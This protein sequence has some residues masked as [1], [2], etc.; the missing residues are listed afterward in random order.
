MSLS[1]SDDGEFR[2]GE[3]LVPAADI[4][5][6]GTSVLD[7]DGLLENPIQLHE[8]LKE[9]CGGQLWPAGVALVKYLLHEQRRDAWIGKQMYV[10]SSIHLT[11]MVELREPVE[12]N[13]APEAALSVWLW[14]A[15]FVRTS[16]THISM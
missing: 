11:K 6:A 13:W 12:S 14:Q 8:D 3:D 5:Q 15:P 10:V 2:V 1:D 9:G 16:K 4:K 7:F